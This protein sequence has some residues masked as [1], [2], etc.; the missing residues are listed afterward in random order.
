MTAQ[1]DQI[2]VGLALRSASGL[3]RNGRESLLR[4]HLHTGD[5]ARLSRSDIHD[6]TGEWPRDGFESPAQLARDAESCLRACERAGISVVVLGDSGYPS[7]LTEI[8]Y[9][10]LVLFVRGADISE[11]RPAGPGPV[12]VVG[13]RQP[14]GAGR[15]LAWDLGAMLAEAGIP[16]VSGLARGIDAASHAGALAAS[17][18]AL[19]VLGCGVDVIYPPSNRG[20]GR[21]ILKAGGALVSEYPP[22][23][24]PLKHHFPARNRIISGLSPLTVV[25]EAPARSGAL[26]T[27]DFAL[28]QGR[29]VAV[30]AVALGSSRGEGAAAL[31]RDGAAVIG[32]ADEV[33]SLLGPALRPDPPA[34][35]MDE[36]TNYLSS[37]GAG[38]VSELVLSGDRTRTTDRMEGT[39]P[40]TN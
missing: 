26:I 13:T 24:P 12:S 28:D 35:G 7:L 20:L 10:P 22:G 37:S 40:W 18:K 25:V 14:T 8:H 16:V 27:A 2:L 15:D 21:A 19:A 9:A 33:I 1:H 3:S 17:G 39:G 11:F 29:D 31:A 32:H 4:E 38:E 34:G 5:F 36:S 23:T 6:L 30:T